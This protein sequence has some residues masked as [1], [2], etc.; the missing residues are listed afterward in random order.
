M[1]AVHWP[2]MLWYRLLIGLAGRL[3]HPRA[4]VRLRVHRTA[5]A[6]HY[7]GLGGDP[8]RDVVADSGSRRVPSGGAHGG[9]DLLAWLDRDQM[10]L[11]ERINRFPTPA[12]NRE[13]YF[14]LAAYFAL[15]R[16]L[17]GEDAL[18]AGLRHLFRGLATSARVL[19]RFP[20]L[21]S[22]YGRLCAEE[23]AQRRDTLPVLGDD[24]RQPVHQL[25]AALRC[26][27]GAGKPPDDAWLAASVEEARRG[28][29]PVPPS[30]WRRLSVPFLP[31]FLWGCRRA[32]RTGVRLPWLRRRI[33]RRAYGT[34][35]SV[36]RPRFDPNRQMDSLP[37]A[38][39]GDGHTYPEWDYRR[40]AYRSDW[41]HVV[42]QV[43]RTAD[44]MGFDADVTALAHRVRRQFEVL[45][46][47]RAWTRGLE[48][49]DEL[50][51]EAF[52]DSVADR[53][54]RGL[55]S[56]RLYRQRESRQRDLAVAV[57][58][59]ASRSTAAWVGEHRVIEV[60]RQSMAILAE[61]LGAAG[62]EFA[63]YGFA[64]DSR[65]RV[66]CHRL[67]GFAERYDGDARRRL[68]ALAPGD[69][70]RMGAVIRHVGA[71]LQERA[72]ARKL[73]LVLTDG[74]PYDPTDGYE[75]RYALEDTRRALQEM[76]T[77]GV[78]CFGLTIDRR[79]GGWLPALFGPGH[80]A[81]F[82]RPEA[83]PSVLPRLY[84]RITGL[85]G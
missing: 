25:E 79:G 73:M 72:H 55:R 37:S 19:D 69:Y 75:G 21:T 48:S 8:A 16:A 36:A 77:R 42:E 47:V 82:S 54:S 30:H 52:V 32:E 74:R 23:L 62:D 7:H 31:V 44:H 83:L 33:R 10:H 20:A 6:L 50:D 64:S 71:G 81:V 84:A 14:W 70:T 68:L 22:R 63:L 49:G 24:A 41:C 15:D 67:K 66:R 57:L 61:A 13:L 29:C 28:R 58:L 11:P 76:R 1:G 26:A 40:R 85:G 65:L 43:P 9:T 27:L 80:Y 46:E 12:L 45:R 51:L 35:K 53:R 39:A 38:A 56:L 3:R 18:P 5:L 4:A 17:D 59:D 34:R 60:A 78:H 2:A